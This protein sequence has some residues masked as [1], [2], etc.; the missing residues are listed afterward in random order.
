MQS[1]LGQ[2]AAISTSLCW[3]FTSTFFTIGGKHVGSVIVN[4]TRLAIAVIYLSIA[5]LVLF[6]SPF[7][8]HAE[9]F[10]IFWLG[11][12]G[13]IGLAIGDAFLFQAFVLIGPHVSMVLMS[14]VPI[15]SA[16]IAWF[17]LNESLSLVKIGAIIL[18]ISGVIIV[19]FKKRD[20]RMKKRK[21]YLIGILCGIGGA[22]GQAFGLIA[23]KKG[24]AGDFAGLS[25]TLIRVSTATLIIWIF[26]LIVG[27]ATN[28]VKRL[29]NKRALVAIAAGAFAGPF[30]GIWLSMIA[31]KF[32]RIG[33]ASTLMA[34]PPVFLL[35]LSYIFFKE[36]ITLQ[37]AVGTIIAVSGIAL[38]F[39][40]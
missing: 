18:T 1:L 13:I 12:S 30:L 38:I 39:L 23:A 40:T 37:S 31:I 5:H 9:P 24:L 16:A 14:L 35:P 3:A 26:T 7:P 34:L 11:I 8:F 6:G 36:K 22:F 2:I 19:V 4:R 21:I 10:R 15:I 17:F 29:K 25:A 20:L 33:I 27:Q 28:T 32:T